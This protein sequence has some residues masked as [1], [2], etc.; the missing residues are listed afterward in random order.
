MPMELECFFTSLSPVRGQESRF[1]GGMGVET[2]VVPRKL[3]ADVISILPR[4]KHLTC[5]GA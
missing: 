5:V 2:N 4:V 1:M 3:S